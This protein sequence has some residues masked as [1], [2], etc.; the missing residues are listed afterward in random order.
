[1]IAGAIELFGDGPFAW[2]IGSIV[3]RL[4]RDPRHVRARARRRRR[5]LVGARASALMACDNLVL[6]HGRIGTLDIYVL[7]AM[8]WGVALYLRG[9]PLRAGVVLGVGACAKLVAPY[10]L[11]VLVLIEAA[12]RCSLRAAI[13]NGRRRAPARRLGVCAAAVSGCSSRCSR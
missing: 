10:A 4:D 6:V 9:R 12:A 1:M 11:L 2:R 13:G 8:V 7:A 5:A 3:L